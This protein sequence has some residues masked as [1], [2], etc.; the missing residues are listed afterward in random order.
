MTSL[1]SNR[2]VGREPLTSERIRHQ[3]LVLCETLR[4][5]AATVARPPVLLL[6]E[7]ADDPRSAL[8]PA[9]VLRVLVLAGS[10]DSVAR[11]A[12]VELSTCGVVDLQT[13]LR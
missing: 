7:G 10:F 11:D 6:T 8:M 5:L 12:F 1:V 9:T 13:S 4:V 2:V 3:L